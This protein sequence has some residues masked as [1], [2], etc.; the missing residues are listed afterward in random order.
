MMLKSDKMKFNLLATAYKYCFS[1][2][3]IYPN[4]QTN[5][6]SGSYILGN[7]V[8]PDMILQVS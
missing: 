3:E 5:I 6:G 1:P 4:L 7:M 2:K 8:G